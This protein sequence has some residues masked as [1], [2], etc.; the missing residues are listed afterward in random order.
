[1]GLDKAVVESNFA[2]TV[3]AN[4]VRYSKGLEDGQGAWVVLK[5][6]RIGRESKAGKMV[7]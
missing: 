3:G 4:C 1:M 5:D 6:G 7:N 2:L